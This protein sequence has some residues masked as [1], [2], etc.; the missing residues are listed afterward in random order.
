[1]TGVLLTLG[2]CCSGDGSGGTRISQWWILAGLLVLWL[3]IRAILNKKGASV[4]SKIGKILTVV[5]LAVVVLGVVVMKRNAAPVSPTPPTSQP[6]VA[7]LPRLVDLGSTTCIPCKMMTPILD[8]L[9]KE[10]AGRMQVEF[11]NIAVDPAAGKAYGI[12]LIPTQVFFDAAGKEL[13]RHEGFISRQDILAK[14]KELGV[15]FADAP[16]ASSQPT[17]DV[18]AVLTRNK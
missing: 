1:M 3:L 9:E 11:I 7:G 2:Q 13:W 10:Y 15:S 17:S 16:S 18:A 12:K 6:A 14:W 5:V 8:E 4:M